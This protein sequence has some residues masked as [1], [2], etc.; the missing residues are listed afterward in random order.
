MTK[1]DIHTFHAYLFAPTACIC[2]VIAVLGFIGCKGEAGPP[3]PSGNAD[4]SM[5]TFAFTASDLLFSSTDSSYCYVSF[6]DPMIASRFSSGA[7]VLLYL[8]ADSIWNPLPYTEPHAPALSVN[9]FFKG[10][11]LTIEIITSYGNARDELTTFLN[12]ETFQVRLILIPANSFYSL[13]S[14]DK[15]SSYNVIKALLR[16]PD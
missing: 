15:R 11:S 4:V 1:R 8:Y 14:I 12:T 10:Q 2:L 5:Y 6:S 13:S 9:Y 3:G 16:L 7:A